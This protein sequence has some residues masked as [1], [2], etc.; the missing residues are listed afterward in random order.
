MSRFVSMCRTRDLWIITPTTW[1]LS[2]RDGPRP[3]QSRFRV[4]L[5][6]K[7]WEA[8]RTLTRFRNRFSPLCW[9][10]NRKRE[11]GIVSSCK[12]WCIG[13]CAFHLLWWVWPDGKQ[14]AQVER[15]SCFK[16]FFAV[17]IYLELFSCMHMETPSD[18]PIDLINFFSQNRYKTPSSSSLDGNVSQTLVAYP[19]IAIE[20][21]FSRWKEDF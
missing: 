19:W 3:I 6:F 2:Y 16:L 12:S 4:S 10:F 15:G 8:E 20:I 14:L 21:L 1:S 13:V 11:S 7:L 5:E 9:F 17:P 18:Y